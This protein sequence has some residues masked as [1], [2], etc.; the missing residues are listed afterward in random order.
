MIGLEMARRTLL[1]VSPPVLYAKNW[2]G[3]RIANKPHLSS[4]AG[5]VRDFTDIRILELDVTTEGDDD[6]LIRLDEHLTDSVGLVGI[7]CWTSLH[8]LGALAT[9]ERVRLIAP[10]IPIVV[11]GHHATALPGDFTHAVCDWLVRGDGEYALR[12]LC[13][14]WPRRPSHME[15]IE[16]GVFDQSNPEDI[17]WARYG[18]WPAKDRAIWVGTSRGCAFQCRFC[19]EPQRGSAYSGY[20]VDD[21]LNIIEGLVLSHEPRVIAF[22]DPLFGVNR[23]WTEA[24]LDGVQERGLPVM[25]WAE[26]RADLM[27]RERL[28]RFRRCN[29]M[30]DFGLD[31]GSETMVQRMEK[32]ANPGVYLARSREVL[33]HA[34]DIGLHHGVYIVFNFPGET[35]QT[36]RETRDFIDGLGG[37]DGSMSGWLACQTF[38]ILPGTHAFDR[39]DTNTAT[40]GTKIRHPVWWREIGDHHA[41]ATDV[42]PSAAWVGREDEL[43][44]FAEWNQDV[45]DRWSGRYSSDVRQFRHTFY[46]G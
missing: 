6:Q 10:H 22:S 34:D 14:Q 37:E 26:T 30:L 27:T 29:F 7:S 39:M 4:L 44:S 32:A 42:L 36:Q 33:A 21:A 41:L 43:C 11:G 16:G 45:N 20:S 17:D 24:F 19:V 8:Y 31:T 40:Y 38:F 18:R 5:Y 46:V 23:R 9:A 1:L 28:D 25:F 2:W 3:N 15:V 12:A 13:A 35:P